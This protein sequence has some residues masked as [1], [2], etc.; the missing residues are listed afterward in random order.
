MVSPL[1][2][3]FR[4]TSDANR[5][6]P[7]SLR[8]IVCHGFCF[9]VSLFSIRRSGPVSRLPRGLLGCDSAR[10]LELPLSWGIPTFDRAFAGGE[11][12]I[13]CSAHSDG[14]PSRTDPG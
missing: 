7:T 6:R 3:A 8:R 10:R 4:V 9:S 14:F 13:G 12:Q 1:R 2:F 5:V 11:T